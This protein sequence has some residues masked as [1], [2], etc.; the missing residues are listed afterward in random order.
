[1]PTRWFQDGQ[2]KPLLPPITPEFAGRKCL[3]LVLDETL[4]PSSLKV[5]VL[6]SI[7]LLGGSNSFSVGR[8]FTGLHRS[9]RDRIILAQLLRAEASGSGRV[10]Q[11]YG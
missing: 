1:M 3:V 8:S 4:V 2:P 6:K 7:V 9:C 11:A 5:R 10:P